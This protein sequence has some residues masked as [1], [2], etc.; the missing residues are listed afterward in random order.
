MKYLWLAMLFPALCLA[1]DSSTFQVGD[2][3]FTKPAKWESVQPASPMRKAQ[4]RVPG[5]K[6]GEGADVVFFHFGAG[7]GGGT[8]ANIDRW[9]AQFR[10]AKDMKSEKTKIGKTGVI[11]ASTHGT[12]LGGMPGGAPQAFEN[13]AL[14][15]AIIESTAGNIFIKMTGPAAVVKS[16]DADFRKMIEGALK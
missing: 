5:A 14:L 3:T 9:F 13:Y 1:A 2:F 4:L 12:Y 6:A 15:G 11:F 10:D 8:Q 16:A 7:G